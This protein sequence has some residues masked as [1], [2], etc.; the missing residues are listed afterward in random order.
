MDTLPSSYP[1]PWTFLTI[2]IPLHGHPS[3]WTTIP[4]NI[5]AHIHLPMD[6]PGHPTHGHPSLWTPLALHIPPHE[7]PFVLMAIP[8]QV[9][10]FASLAAPSYRAS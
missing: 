1:S 4:V 10:P 5:P 8:F 6:I 9:Q 7:C 2:R 3:P